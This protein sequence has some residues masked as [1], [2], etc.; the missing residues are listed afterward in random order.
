M[1]KEG[2]IEKNYIITVVYSEM[3]IEDCQILKKKLHLF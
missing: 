3:E 2:L 1:G